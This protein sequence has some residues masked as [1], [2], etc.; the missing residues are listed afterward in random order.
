MKNKKDNLFYW[1]ISLKNKEDIIDNYYFSDKVIIKDEEFIK[2]IERFRNLIK[3][4]CS[5]KEIIDK[6]NKESIK[7]EIYKII[8]SVD[9][10]QY[11]EFVAFW[12]VLD[13]SFSIF[14]KIKGDTII[15]D[16]LLEEYCKKRE[17]IYKNLCS[18]NITV[19]ALYDSGVSRKKGTSGTDKIIKVIKTL[20]KN[21]NKQLNEIDSVEEF[22]KTDVGYF[23]PDKGD[24]KLFNDFCRDMRIDFSFKKE[25]QGK[26]PDMV[27]K[28]NNHFF[29]IEAKHIKESGGAQ[30]KQIT[31]II[32]FIKKQEKARN[33]HYVSFMDGIYFNKFSYPKNYSKVK[34]QKKDIKTNLKKNKKNYFVNTKGFQ[35]LI[36]DFLNIKKRK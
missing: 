27:L 20:A 9:N 2:K 33:V 31:E 8:K 16:K 30:D 36:E 4:Y 18:S 35:E 12:K 21:H 5:V 10:I 7:K 26:L 1:E 23:L 11:T 25:H 22:K 17:K 14:K 3:S 29:I 15:L 13:I 32:E 6:K 24:K 28:I 34:K 19:Q